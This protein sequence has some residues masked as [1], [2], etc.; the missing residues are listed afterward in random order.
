MVIGEQEIERH[1]LRELRGPA[2]AA[3]L[4]VELFRERA[5]GVIE[6]NGLESVGGGVHQR[7]LV[8]E[9][10]E[11]LSLQIDLR[12]LTLVGIGHR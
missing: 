11:A 9:R 1:S 10:G 3:A 2:E 5:E 4:A 7:L 6:K 12:T 8:D